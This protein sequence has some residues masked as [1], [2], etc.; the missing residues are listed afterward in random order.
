[1][2]K[3]SASTRSKRSTT[4][5]TCDD[6]KAMGTSVTSVSTTDLN[7]LSNNDFS[8]CAETL[9]AMT[10]WDSEQ[11]QALATKAKAAWGAV[12]TW[13]TEEVRQAGSIIGGLTSS[14][15]S[16]L[17]LNSND[18]MASIGKHAFDSMHL[19]NG[20]ARWLSQA[21]SG[22]TGSV[23]ASDLSTIGHFACGA[24]TTHINGFTSSVYSDAASDIG[25]LTTCE[26]SQLGA[27][28]TKAK[29]AFGQDVTTWTTTTVTTVGAVIGGLPKSDLAK[30]SSDQIAVISTSSMEQIP[31]SNFAGF[32]TSQLEGLTTSQANAVTA[33]QQNALSTSQRNALQT[34][35]ATYKVTTGGA[36]HAKLSVMLLFAMLFFARL[37]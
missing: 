32:T 28:A 4:S 11:L 29:A 5:T 30:L 37:F 17:D 7:T 6:L 20:F 18:A 19:S 14:E 3:A 8:D 15:V 35:G 21:K 36:G 23:T 27:Y 31:P 26:S 33:E 1:L 13:T 2:K 10:G 12:N 16:Q 9:G 22:Q 24:T 25:D 34:A